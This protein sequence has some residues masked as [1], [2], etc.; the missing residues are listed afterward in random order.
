MDAHDLQGNYIWRA[1]DEKVYVRNKG[2]YQCLRCQTR[3]EIYR[4]GKRNP[5]QEPKT[6]V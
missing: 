6:Y 2:F 1:W 3:E 4:L 5:D